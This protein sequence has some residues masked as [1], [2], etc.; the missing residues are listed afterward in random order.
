MAWSVFQWVVSPLAKCHSHNKGALESDCSKFMIRE[1][2]WQAKVRGK[3]KPKEVLMCRGMSGG[4]AVRSSP[5]WRA[6][7]NTIAWLDQPSIKVHPKGLLMEKNGFQ[8]PRFAVVKAKGL[9]HPSCVG[10]SLSFHCR[11]LMF[12]AANKLNKIHFLFPQVY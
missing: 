1:E 2:P 12:S 5:V 6:N 8:F 3:D 10:G 9:F 7:L 11:S 4:T